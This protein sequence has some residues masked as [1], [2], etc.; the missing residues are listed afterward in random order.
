MNKIE[1]IQGIPQ[2]PDQVHYRIVAASTLATSPS[3]SI[4]EAGLCDGYVTL[5]ARGESESWL[6]A[7]H[8]PVN[9]LSRQTLEVTSSLDDGLVV[10]PSLF[11]NSIGNKPRYVTSDE[12]AK[13]LNVTVHAVRKLR[14]QGRI[15]PHQFGRSVRY[16]VD[17]VVAALTRKGRKHE[18]SRR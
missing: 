1:I 7:L 3:E 10:K 4:K 14:Q 13:Q 12:L 18:K 8:H 5:P 17:E 2:K 16:V 6:N 15:T 11:D 9:E